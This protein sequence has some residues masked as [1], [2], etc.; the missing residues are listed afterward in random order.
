[1]FHLMVVVQGSCDSHVLVSTGMHM[2]AC[3]YVHVFEYVSQFAKR[4]YLSNCAFIIY[5]LFTYSSLPF[6]LPSF[7][8]S[9]FF[10]KLI[11]LS[12]LLFVI[13]LFHVLY[14]ISIFFFIFPS[15]ISILFFT[16]P[17]SSSSSILSIIYYLLE[18]FNGRGLFTAYKWIST[19]E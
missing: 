15:I 1:M 10:L 3:A 9:L 13:Q 6:F 4:C 7:N 19:V 18:C 12:S 2:L 8:S 14:I 16:S 17:L 5:L 11:I